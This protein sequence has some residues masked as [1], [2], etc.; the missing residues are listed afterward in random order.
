MSK[1]Q[2]AMMGMSNANLNI[3]SIVIAFAVFSVDVFLGKM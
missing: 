3:P 2:N 1:V